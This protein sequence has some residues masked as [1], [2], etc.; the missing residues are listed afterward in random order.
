VRFANPFMLGPERIRAAAMRHAV[1]QRAEI[2]HQH[3]DVEYQHA[4]QHEHGV[5]ADPDDAHRLHVSA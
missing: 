2:D 4:G 1:R 3:H 5:E